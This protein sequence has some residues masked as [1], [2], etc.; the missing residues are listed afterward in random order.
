MDEATQGA[1]QSRGRA[2]P[3]AGTRGIEAVEVGVVSVEPGHHPRER[4]T[5]ISAGELGPRSAVCRGH[6]VG[7][8]KS[9]VDGPD[10][11]QRGVLQVED[12]LG[13]DGV[14]H[15]EQVAARFGLD[16]EVAV[17][18]PVHLHQVAV[19][20]PHSRQR[21]DH[22][23]QVEFWHACTQR[24]GRGHTHARILASARARSRSRDRA[25]VLLPQ[26]GDSSGI[27]RR[28]RPASLRR[29]PDARLAVLPHEVALH[30]Y[31]ATPG[32]Y[33]GQVGRTGLDD[34]ARWWPSGISSDRGNPNSSID[35]SCPKV[36]PRLP[37]LPTGSVID[38]VLPLVGQLIESVS[39]LLE[40]KGSRDVPPANVQTQD[41]RH[42]HRS[43][44]QLVVIRGMLLECFNVPNGADAVDR[45][46]RPTCRSGSIIRSCRVRKSWRRSL[47]QVREKLPAQ[48]ETPRSRSR[49]GSSWPFHRGWWVTPRAG[50]RPGSAYAEAGQ[51]TVRTSALAEVTMVDLSLT[52]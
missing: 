44:H 9:R 22:G 51:N 26:C 52:S 35:T 16:P 45:R 34:F 1:A 8:R 4:R 32:L 14:V 37:P 38:D 43:N 17:A 30:R 10:V 41:V 25:P 27:Q 3:V 21:A 42:G 23:V 49:W 47:A 29:E 6:D 15:L 5:A 24:I 11:T 7:H 39:P 19:Q 46:R 18:L 12:R 33:L 28:S 48:T 40:S 13:L 20:S 2:A 31:L 36:G 50:G